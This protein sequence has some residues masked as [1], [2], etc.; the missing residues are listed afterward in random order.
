M[1]DPVV[2]AAVPA[3]VATLQALQTFMANLGTDPAQVPAKLPGALQV[4]LGT[5]ELQFPQLV[6]SEVGALQ[7][8]IN[9]K[10]NGWITMLQ[11]IQ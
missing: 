10:V 8:D 9:T 6:T 5:V 3:L 7:T 1:A 4:F 2:K 11:A